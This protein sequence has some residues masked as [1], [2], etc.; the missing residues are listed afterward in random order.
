VILRGRRPLDTRA[1]PVYEE[2]ETAVFIFGR[3]LSETW[4]GW[5]RLQSKSFACEIS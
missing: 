2:A 4:P 1:K 5:P 3:H